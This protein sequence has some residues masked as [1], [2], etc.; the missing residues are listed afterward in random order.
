M[1][2]SALPKPV[3]ILAGLIAGVI[4]ALTLLFAVELASTVVHPFPPDFAG[5]QEAMCAHVARYPQWVLAVVVPAW[6]FTAF[7][8]TWTARRLGTFPAAIPIGLLLIAGVL[9]NVAMLPYP[10]WFKIVS[11]IAV[12]AAVIAASRS[13][14]CA[15]SAG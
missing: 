8:A 15:G 10:L 4:I 13:R 5:T 6:G 2:L 12:V 3:R 1:P 14:C 7:A 11:P 9:F